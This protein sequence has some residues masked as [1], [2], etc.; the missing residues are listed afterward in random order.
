VNEHIRQQIRDE[1]NRLIQLHGDEI[2]KHAAIVAA[3]VADLHSVMGNCRQ[4][5]RH[6]TEQCQGCEKRF[7]CLEIWTAIRDAEENHRQKASVHNAT[8][9]AIMAKCSHPEWESEISDLGN[10]H[11]VDCWSWR[12]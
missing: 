5:I 3:L 12:D 9:D 6:N 1:K 11:C 7:K 8:N 10:E 2:E 4:H